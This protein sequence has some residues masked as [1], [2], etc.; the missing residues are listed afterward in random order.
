MEK[1][2]E[3][4]G[5]ERGEWERERDTMREAISQLRDSMRENCEKMEKMEGRHKVCLSFDPQT[6]LHRGKREIV[7]FFRQSCQDVTHCHE[8]LTYELASL[9]AQRTESQQLIRDLEDENKALRET[10]KEGNME[11]D[12]QESHAGFNSQSVYF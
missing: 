1:E 9:T 3:S 12:R 2:K 5:R 4:R 11:L 6:R 7:F 10:E 8:N